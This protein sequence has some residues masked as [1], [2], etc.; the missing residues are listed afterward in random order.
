MTEQQK[1]WDEHI[2]RFLLAYRSAVHDSTSKS[3]AKGFFGTEIKLLDDLE[4]GIK[5]TTEGN[6]TCTGKEQSLNELHEFVRT[7]IKMVSDR[8]K[9][10]YDRAANQRAFKRDSWFYYTTHSGRND[11][12]PS[13]KPAWMDRIK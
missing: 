13:Y 10:G 9:A 4:F 3:P 7:R 8:M 5:P 1:D 12:P 2:P 11:Y 6:D